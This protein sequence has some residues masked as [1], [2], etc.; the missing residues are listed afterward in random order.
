MSM[1]TWWTWVWVNSGSWWWT[2]RPGVL[3]SMGLQRV[4]HDWATEL[5]WTEKKVVMPFAAT[6]MDLEIVILSEVSQRKRNT[7]WYSLFEESKRDD[8]KWTY[9]QS[10]NRL[11]DLENKLLVAGVGGEW[12]GQLGTLGLV[13]PSYCVWSRQLTRVYLCSTGTLPNTVWQ[14]AWEKKWRR[15]DTCVCKWVTL[16]DIWNYY[17]TVNQL[18]SNIK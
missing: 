8:T 13:S 15:I 14:P 2:G 17:N 7:V 6:W 5:N 12:G 10:R 11:R 4:G 18:S 1:P 3:R 16:L 9:L